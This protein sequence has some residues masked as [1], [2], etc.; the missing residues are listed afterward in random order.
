[1]TINR[2]LPAN[3][4]EFKEY[5]ENLISEESSREKIIK[6]VGQGQGK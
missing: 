2:I 1:L 6:A 4:E 5:L 3:P